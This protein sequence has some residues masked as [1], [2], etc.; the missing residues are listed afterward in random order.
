MITFVVEHPTVSGSNAH[1][2]PMVRHRRVEAE[3]VALAVAWAKAT[4]NGSVAGLLEPARVLR[5]PRGLTR[6]QRATAKA[7]E[8]D[9]RTY[10]RVL[11]PVVPLTVKLTRISPRRLDDDNL[12]AALKGMRDEIAWQMGIDDRHP[13]VKWDYDSPGQERGPAKYQAVRVVIEQRGGR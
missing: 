6:E 2:L 10:H 8:I 1:E 3:R 9:L 5:L 11:A 4:R 7:F 12:R 13:N